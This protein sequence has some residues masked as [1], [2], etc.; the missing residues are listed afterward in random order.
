MRI[1]TIIAAAAL[2]AANTAYA[3][4]IQTGNCTELLDVTNVTADLMTGAAIVGV[5]ARPMGGAGATLELEWNNDSGTTP[6]AL[7]YV[8]NCSANAAGDDYNC[9]QLGEFDQVT[10]GS[11]FARLHVTNLT[12]LLHSFFAVRYD[13]GGTSPQ[14]DVNLRVCFE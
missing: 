7:V 3:G 13:L 6:T 10:T 2:L 14:Y 4:P 9:Q 12:T 1:K 11:G 5:P 8:D